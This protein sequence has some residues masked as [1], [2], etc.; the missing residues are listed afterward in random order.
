MKKVCHVTSVHPR[1]DVRIF[2][3]ECVSLAKAGYDVSLVV[4]DT[5]PNEVCDGVKIIST[6]YKPKNR[7]DRIFKSVDIVGDCALQ[8]DAD[9]YHLHDP[10]LLQ[11]VSKLQK[12]GKTV[13]F[14]AHEDVENQILDKKWIPGGLRK[15]LSKVYSIYASRVL[16]KVAA[17]VTV[18]PHLV[19]KNIKNNPNTILVTNYPI[20]RESVECNLTDNFKHPSLCF[21]GGIHNQYNH[22][23]IL[24]AIENIDDIKYALAGRATEEYLAK[25][26]NM[27]AWS[28]VDYYGVISHD[29]VYEMYSKASIGMAIHFSSQLA[30]VGSLGVLKLFEFMGAGIPV[31]CT[32]YPLWQEI[33]DKYKCGIC[34]DPHS[35]EEIRSA[36][37]K[38]INNPEEAMAMGKRGREAAE[39][40]FSWVL[41]EKKL[42]SLYKNL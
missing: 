10:E 20:L 5:L 19:T 28:K 41:E 40:E 31:V 11:L 15:P 26:K 27:P 29:E 8:V 38:L 23:N 36:I 18:T 12:K 37:Q 22:E 4:N 21:A 14:D 42:I 9:I 35:V 17:I 25:L 2:E 7:I 24:E 16:S 34:V 6:Q 13:I 32:N 30:G 1:K 3:K 33:I 39:N